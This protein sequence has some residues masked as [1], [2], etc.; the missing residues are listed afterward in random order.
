[1]LQ[2]IKLS[3]TQWHSNHAYFLHFTFSCSATS[4]CGFLRQLVGV[5]LMSKLAD[6]WC[7]LFRLHLSW[8]NFFQTFFQSRIWSIWTGSDKTLD[9]NDKMTTWSSGVDMSG[10]VCSVARVVK[11]KM[12]SMWFFFFFWKVMECLLLLELHL[13]WYDSNV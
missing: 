10:F 11:G 9:W 6:L 8:T 1:M 3:V 12:N 2:C 7:L 13:L 4:Y 5:F